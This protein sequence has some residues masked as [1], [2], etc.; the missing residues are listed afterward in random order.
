MTITCNLYEQWIS[1]IRVN[2]V[3]HGFDPSGLDD[4][5]CAVRWWSWQRRTVRPARRQVFRADTFSC[6]SSLQ[7]G[8]SGLEA[9]IRSGGAVWPW[10]S[11]GIDRHL[12]EDAMFND[13]GVLHFH[14]GNGF[15]AGGYVNRT[16]ELL[17]AL[18][19]PKTF[20][21]IGI[22]DHSDWHELDVLNIL[23][24][25]WPALLDSFVVPAPVALA[26]R[27]PDEIRKMRKARINIT[28][29]LD[30]G[31]HIHSPGGGQTA[32][33]TSV[34]AMIDAQHW[35][36]FFRNAESV[37]TTEIQSMIREGTLENTDYSVSLECSEDRIAAYLPDRLRW[38]LWK[39]K[40][41]QT[42]PSPA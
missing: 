8:L 28:F 9:E 27:A 1:S 40:T 25:N 3:D 6:P 4:R 7:V 11:K 38:I 18:V 15:E 20:Y 37:V 12:D 19:T 32:D 34:D 16:G 22:F 33:G 29:A 23:E 31:R 14:L 5:D 35:S 10:Q 36:K 42:T 21:Q 13:F 17:F 39:R 24:R 26:L 30:S 2:F 41:D